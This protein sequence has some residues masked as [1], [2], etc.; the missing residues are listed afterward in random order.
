LKKKEE[1]DLKDGNNRPYP[2]KPKIKSKYHLSLQA[3]Q[4][5]AELGT[6]QPQLAC[7]GKSNTY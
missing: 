2:S 4:V 5:L 1:G 3:S 7:D 6:A